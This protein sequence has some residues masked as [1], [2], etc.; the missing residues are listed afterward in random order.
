[1]RDGVAV[2]GGLNGQSD[3]DDDLARGLAC[4]E[5]THRVR[6]FGQWVGPLNE[7][8]NLAFGCEGG[9][10]VESGVVL[11]VASPS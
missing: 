6:G 3:S 4:R 1:M 9:E 5:V 8:G 7:G 10:P 11:P 2:T